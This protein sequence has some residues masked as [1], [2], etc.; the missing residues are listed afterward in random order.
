MNPSV[1]NPTVVKPFVNPSVVNLSVVNISVVNTSVL[2]LA[3]VNPSVV[4]PFVN[5][6]VVN[7]SVVNPL[8]IHT[9]QV[10]LRFSASTALTEAERCLGPEEEAADNGNPTE[11]TAAGTPKILPEGV[12]ATDVGVS[13]NA[14]AKTVTSTVTSQTNASAIVR[15]QSLGAETLLPPLDGLHVTHHDVRAMRQR[16]KSCHLG[17]NHHHY[18]AK[19]P[20]PKV[21][22]SLRGG[23]SVG[24]ASVSANAGDSAHFMDDVAAFFGIGT[25]AAAGGTLPRPHHIEYDVTFASGPIG[26]NLETDWYGERTIVKGFR[27]LKM[28]PP[29]AGGSSTSGGSGSFFGGG[30]PGPAETCGRIKPGDILVA[31]NAANVQHLD[32]PSVMQLLRK[33]SS[34]KHTLSFERT[35][36]PWRRG[37]AGG[38]TRKLST[39]GAERLLRPPLPAA[40]TAHP[41]PARFHVVVLEM[42]PVFSEAYE[43]SEATCSIQ[44][45]VPLELEG[46]LQIMM[47][48]PCPYNFQREGGKGRKT[49]Q[50]H[51]SKPQE[52]QLQPTIWKRGRRGTHIRSCL[53]IGESFEMEMPATFASRSVRSREGSGGVDIHIYDKCTE[54]SGEDAGPTKFRS[55]ATSGQPVGGCTVPVHHVDGRKRWYRLRNNEGRESV[56]IALSASW[57]SLPRRLVEERRKTMVED[58]LFKSGDAAPDGDYTEDVPAGKDPLLSIDAYLKIAAVGDVLLFKN[59]PLVSGIQRSLTGSKWDHVAMVVPWD[60]V[61]KDSR[62]HRL[63]IFESTPAGVQSYPLGPRLMAYSD[64]FAETLA[65]RKLLLLDANAYGQKEKLK[66]FA[67]K[68]DPSVVDPPVLNPSVVNPPVVNPSVVN[69][70]VVNPSVVNHSVVNPSVVHHPF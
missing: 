63:H 6:S 33:V 55:L 28:P 21:S 24:G 11:Q 23:T 9:T 45:G 16:T 3:V 56:Q 60:P 52:Y 40:A 70:S 7:P 42:Q 47:R 26:L 41:T 46:P 48:C 64:G 25:A 13:I 51:L 10:L 12:A 4:R 37:G 15:A 43:L 53:W 5:L 69:Q 31:V 35:S 2:N 20:S 1:V 39:S 27:R 29:A 38:R 66:L 17:Q 32:F 14:N 34:S 65:C 67:R 54:V 62:R 8:Q 22:A 57:G 18:H 30:S 61:L 49:S 44:D 36:R 58:T 59:K 50:V 68:V 19:P